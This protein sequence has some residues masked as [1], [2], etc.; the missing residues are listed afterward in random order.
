MS[1]ADIVYKMGQDAERFGFLVRCVTEEGFDGM[2][3]LHAAL[4]EMEHSIA[5]EVRKPTEAEFVA[6]IDKARKACK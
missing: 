1:A 4:N 6:V 5:M 2:E 3:K